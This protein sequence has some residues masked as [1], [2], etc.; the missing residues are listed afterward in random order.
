MNLQD[1]SL[2]VFQQFIGGVDVRV[3]QQKAMDLGQGGGCVLQPSSSPALGPPEPALLPY[4]GK[5]WD[6][7]SCLWQ[8]PR[9]RTGTP[10]F[11]SSGQLS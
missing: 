4:P 6:Q 1:Q 3:F 8:I 10:I 9:G 5:H 7:L 2:P 11:M